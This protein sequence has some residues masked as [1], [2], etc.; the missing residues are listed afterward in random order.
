MSKR[1]LYTACQRL[2]PQLAELMED[3]HYH[4]GT[5]NTKEGFKTFVAIQYDRIWAKRG[6]PYRGG[7]A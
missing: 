3:S 5:K 2:P 1:V 7:G 6:H 4:S